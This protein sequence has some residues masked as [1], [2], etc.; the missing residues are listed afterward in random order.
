MGKG[1][2]IIRGRDA[3]SV[4]TFYFDPYGDFD[5]EKKHCVEQEREEL[6]EELSGLSFAMRRRKVEQMMMDGRLPVKVSD[7]R[8]Y[9][10]INDNVIDEID[11]L[12]YQI[13]GTDGAPGF[14]RIPTKERELEAVLVAGNRE[15]GQV[16]AKSDNCH[17]V[18][19]DNESN[20]AIGCVNAET[21]ENSDEN[22][23]DDEYDGLREEAEAELIQTRKRADANYEIDDVDIDKLAEEKLEARQEKAWDELVS[24]Y[25]KDANAAMRKIHEYFGAQSI[26]VRS[27]AWT[28]GRLKPYAELTEEERNSYY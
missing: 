27:C 2:Q 8:I 6:A 20:M 28:S 1:N 13:G 9:D 14:K 17:V 16:I 22:V 10:R 5:A 24:K 21:R 23:R 26:S 19:G 15:Y 4:R 12:A 3:E 18:I 11:N 7:K 25:R